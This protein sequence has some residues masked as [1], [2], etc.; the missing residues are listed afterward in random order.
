MDREPRAGPWASPQ[1]GRQA[2]RTLRPLNGLFRPDRVRVV[3]RL[4]LQQLHELDQREAPLRRSIGLQHCVGDVSVL[5]PYD[6]I[7]VAEVR[8]DE[9]LGPMR[10]EIGSEQR[11]LLDCFGLRG[12][13]PQVQCPGGGDD[14]GQSG[15]LCA[16]ELGCQGAAEE[17][18]GADEED[19]EIVRAHA[20][21]A[22]FRSRSV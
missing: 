10:G 20:S 18:P 15:N 19:P 2:H 22:G 16:E 7:R 14:H 6:E 21:G 3:L 1:R 17:V 12:N 5:E 13:R 9:P 11:R 4:P 8:V